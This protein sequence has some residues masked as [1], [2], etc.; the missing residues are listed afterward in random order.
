M[1][2]FKVVEPY[3]G[4]VCFGLVLC[5][6]FPFLWILCVFYVFSRSYVFVIM[7]TPPQNAVLLYD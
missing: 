7:D 2:E 1:D 3:A 5:G 6:C 4:F